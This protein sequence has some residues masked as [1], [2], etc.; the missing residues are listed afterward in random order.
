MTRDDA[1]RAPRA[2]TRAH[3]RAHEDEAH[4]DWRRRHRHVL[5][6]TSA[7]KPAWTRYGSTHGVSAL[8]ATLQALG[9]VSASAMGGELEGADVGGAAVGETGE[10]RDDVRDV[11]RSRRERGDAGETSGVRRA[12]DED[13]GDERGTGDGAGEEREIRRREGAGDGTRERRRCWGSW[14]GI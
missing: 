5:A 7:G 1:A 4:D 13:A 6:F 11:E 2:W 8:C 14:R 12:G 10:R 3:K 9:A